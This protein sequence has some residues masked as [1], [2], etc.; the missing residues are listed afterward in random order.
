MQW[1]AEYLD[2]GEILQFLL[3][4]KYWIVAAIPIIIVIAV[5]RGLTR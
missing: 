1:F 4:N 5:V 3:E 2:L